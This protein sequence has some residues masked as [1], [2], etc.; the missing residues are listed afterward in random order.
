MSPHLTCNGCGITTEENE[1][2]CADIESSLERGWTHARD[3]SYCPICAD[4]RSQT[5]PGTEATDGK[6]E[7][8]I[9]K[10]TR[11]VRETTIRAG[12]AGIAGGFALA[13]IFL[14]F[15]PYLAGVACG[16]FLVVVSAVALAILCAPEIRREAKTRR[17]RD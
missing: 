1:N 15:T 12:V 16:V 8:M 11:R 7:P 6:A 9:P 17:M 10:A 13:T 14:A 5:W 4:V 2:G 3:E